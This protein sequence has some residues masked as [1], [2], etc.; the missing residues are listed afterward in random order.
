[1]TKL[2]LFSFAF[3][4]LLSGTMLKAQTPERGFYKD[5]YMDGGLSLTSKQYLP[6]ART[7]MLS[8]ETLRTG[9]SS[10]GITNADT[11]IQ[12]AL[13]VGNEYD[14]NG[15]LLYPDGAP[16]YRMVYVNGGTAKSHGRSLTA[17][18]RERFR[19]FVK[20]GG[21]YLGSCAGAYL[22]CEGTKTHPKYEEYLGIY[23]GI[24][25]NANLQNK[26]VNITIPKNSPLLK[27]SDFGG[28]FRID[29][30][31]HNGGCYMDYADL[32]PGAEILLNYDYPPKPMHGNGCVWSYKANETTGRVMACGPH[33]EGVTQGEK[34]EMME[35]MVQYVLEGTPAPQIKASINIGEKRAMT[36]RTEDNN[37]SLTRIGDKQYHH[38]TVDVP[39]GTDTLKLQLST[40]NGYTNF[41]MYLF[42]SYDGIAMFGNSKYKN[43]SK[44]SEKELVIVKPKAGKLY[45]SVFC[46]T[47]VD[48][49]E[50]RYGTIY[51]GRMD[52][53]NGVPYT[54]SIKA[55]S[56][57]SDKKI[58]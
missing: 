43:V 49:K 17:A 39:E 29:D 8:I 21:G 34:L 38:F 11:L 13:I 4:T 7:L 6:S 23:P 20:A 24:C 18:G 10:L 58:E 40:E 15:I 54:I 52:V 44:G 48:S 27:Y 56:K 33:P 47:T 26:R 55:G 37:P 2:I 35:A 12:N 45:F 30:I 16:R 51:S 36:C 1:M 5:I 25:T 57:D 19:E 53:L 41:D 9:T 32:I 46:D 42:A 50:T 31:Y 28:D 22:A 14:T 3:V